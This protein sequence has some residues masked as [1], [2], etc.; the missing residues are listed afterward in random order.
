MDNFLLLST[1]WIAALLW[2]CAHQRSFGRPMLAGVDAGALSFGRPK[3]AGVDGAF[4]SSYPNDLDCTNE[5]LQRVRPNL[6]DKGH[7][8]EVDNSGIAYTARPTYFVLV[9]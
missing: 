8:R 4:H 2:E 9:Y 1:M 7:K 5:L 6:I 3:L